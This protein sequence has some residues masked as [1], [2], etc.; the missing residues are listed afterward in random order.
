MNMPASTHHQHGDFNK[1]LMQANPYLLNSF[2]KKRIIN[3][4]CFF[5]FFWAKSVIKAPLTL[6]LIL[7]FHF[8]QIPCGWVGFLQIIYFNF[9][10]CFFPPFLWELCSVARIVL[11]PLIRSGHKKDWLCFI[12]HTS[13]KLHGHLSWSLVSIQMV[14]GRKSVLLC[15]AVSPCWATSAVEQ[16]VRLSS[17]LGI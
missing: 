14:E 3:P 12:S 10:F 4:Y 2:E 13:A 15:L 7:T 6:P 11:S 5:F 9:S 16:N 17:H 1:P 8:S